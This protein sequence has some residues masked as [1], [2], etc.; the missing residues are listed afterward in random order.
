V[1][2]ARD[3]YRLSDVAEEAG[4][5][6]VEYHPKGYPRGESFTTFFRRRAV[7]DDLL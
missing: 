5:P 2:E 4:R 7:E 1:V 6:V 3:S